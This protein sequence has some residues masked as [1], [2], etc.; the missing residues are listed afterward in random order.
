MWLQSRLL[1]KH[2][3]FEGGASLHWLMCGRFMSYEHGADV[4]DGCVCVPATMESSP[5]LKRAPATVASA[6]P[7]RVRQTH[8]ETA[9]LPD[10]F[11]KAVPVEALLLLRR[12]PSTVVLAWLFHFQQPR[13][14]RVC[15]AGVH[16]MLA[17]HCCPG[18]PLKQRLLRGRVMPCE[19]ERRQS[20]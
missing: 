8:M 14:E 6:R 16:A 9:G 5:H 11:A 10:V 15:L 17:S 3:P 7:C 2:L 18:G 19:R 12:I 20:E 1:W 13:T 4:L